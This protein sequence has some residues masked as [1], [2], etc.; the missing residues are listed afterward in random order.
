MLVRLVAP[1]WLLASDSSHPPA[2]EDDLSIE[3]ILEYNSLGYNIYYFP[4]TPT[5]YKKSNVSIAGQDI[6][7]FNWVFVDYDCKTNTYA[8]KDAFIETLVSLSPTKIIDSGNGIHAY[9]KVSDLDVK[10]YLRLNRRLARYF[11]TD[12][13]VGKIAQLMRL[14]DTINTKD[15]NNYKVCELIFE[16]N[17]T[18]SCEQL[19]AF[20]PPISAEDEEY[21]QNHYNMTYQINTGINLNDK[22]PAKWGK[23]LTENAEVKTLWASTIDDRSKGDYRLGHIMY[24]N[25]FTK[26]EAAT[27][28]ANSAKSITRAPQ[29]R[30]SYASNIVSKIWTFEQ[31]P[32]KKDLTL[33]S[34]VAEVLQA[35]GATIEG[36]RFPCHKYIDNTDAGFRLGHVM[37]LVAGSGVGKT[38]MALNI[39]MGFVLSNPEYDHFFCPLEQ[40][41][42]EIALRWKTM[43]G[44]NTAL[45]DKV[46]IISNYD[47]KGTFRDLSLK[48]I[49]D[50][51]LKFQKETDKK[52]GCVVIDHIGVLCNNNKLGQDEGLKGIAKDM[53]GFAIETNT[54]LIMQ[55]QTSRE[56]A[57][58]GDLELNKDAAFGTSVF[59]NYCD[60]LVTIWQPLKRVYSIGAPTIM[61]YKYC[62]IRHKKQGSDVIQ[63]DVPYKM[64]FNPETQ[65][66]RALTQEEEASFRYFLV[67]ATNKRKIDRKTELVE[68]QSV[69]EGETK[70]VTRAVDSNRQTIRH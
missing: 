60:F 21:C 17:I 68:Y 59:E 23:L 12:L 49:K 36:K 55:S 52:I 35:A 7:E 20:L 41:D 46:H 70:N 47:E 2:I 37:G 16:D 56:K 9:W 8:N 26:D 1:K 25:G 14:Q 15:P 38:A 66:L 44:S 43:C 30:L 22:M 18:Y 39:F 4:N 64:F 32:D 34:S 11:K 48:D 10:S 31:A 58:I 57:G 69:Q 33:S 29:H 53:K 42:K 65:T 61:A 5:N 45:H 19:N 27:V 3:A 50:Y 51:I 40:T 54:F 6:T 62:K 67:Q 13:A 24:A 63:E 28:L